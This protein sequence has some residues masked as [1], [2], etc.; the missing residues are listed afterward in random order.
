MRFNFLNVLNV[1][2]KFTYKKILYINYAVIYFKTFCNRNIYV[3]NYFLTFIPLPFNQR[4]ILKASFF[5]TARAICVNTILILILPQ[6]KYFFFFNSPIETI[7]L[8]IHIRQGIPKPLLVGHRLVEC[9]Q[10]G[11]KSEITFTWA[12]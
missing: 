2:F 11:K 1:S 3:M 9:T 6:A 8:V 4:Y 7:S 10:T 5:S 12:T